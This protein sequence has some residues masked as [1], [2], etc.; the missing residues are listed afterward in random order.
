MCINN[1]SQ[2]LERMAGRL[3]EDRI[4]EL[5]KAFSLFDKS[6]N[7]IITAIE[8]GA[9]MR[10]LGQ[11]P[12]EVE[13]QDVINEVDADG[14]GCIDF[15]EFLCI[16][17]GQRMEQVTEEDLIEG[18]KVFDKD[19]NGFISTKEIRHVMIGLGEIFTDQEVDDMI[20]ESDL[21]RDGQINYAEFV[22]MMLSK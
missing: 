2:C 22:K 9:A 16:M 10:S 17:A 18:F 6:G 21:D 20:R 1:G 12:T 7:G 11:H 15:P 13:L 19:G 4:E 3:T 5:K 14:D 8:L